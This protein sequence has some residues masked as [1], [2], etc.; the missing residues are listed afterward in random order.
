MVGIVKDY[1]VEYVPSTLVSAFTEACSQTWYYIWLIVMGF[2]KLVQQVVPMSEIGGPILIA[3]IAAEQLR[4]GWIDLTYF[5]ALLSVNLGI[6]NLLPIPVLDGGH[7]AFLSLEAIRR[8]P[9]T[10]RAQIIA[11][12]IGL[13]LLITLML[14]AFYNDLTG[15]FK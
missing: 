13:A 14:F 12:Q 4:A 9:L 1:Q 11:Q 10:E 2:V 5:I 15:I 3:K 8:K 6:L 7:L